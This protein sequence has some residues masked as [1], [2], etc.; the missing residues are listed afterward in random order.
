MARIKD[1]VIDIVE[2]YDEKGMTVVEIALATGMS[3]AA[4][5]EIVSQYSADFNTV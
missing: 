5:L 1:L 2:M 3:E 4:I